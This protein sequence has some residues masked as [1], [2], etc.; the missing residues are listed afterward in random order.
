MDVLNNA[1]IKNVFYI[2]SDG[3]L[4]DHKIILTESEFKNS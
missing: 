1:S 4:R 2:N 3:D